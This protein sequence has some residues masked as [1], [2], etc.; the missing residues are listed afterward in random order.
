MDFLDTILRHVTWPLTALFGGLTSLI[1]SILVFRTQLVQLLNLV[2][3]ALAN[4]VSNVL[5]KSL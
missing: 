3:P 2:S 5:R 4:L 1:I